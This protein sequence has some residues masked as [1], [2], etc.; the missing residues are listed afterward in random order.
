M[1]DS[2]TGTASTVADWQEVVVL[3]ATRTAGVSEV[4][5]GLGADGT[6]LLGTNGRQEW[7]AN[8]IVGARNGTLTAMG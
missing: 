8:L 4:S 2:G 6:R 1:A 3:R 7:A 5:A